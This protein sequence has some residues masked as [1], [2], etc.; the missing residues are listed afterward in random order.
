M[1][2]A[3]AIRHLDNEAL[4]I[5]FMNLSR[6]FSCEVFDLPEGKG[7]C[8]DCEGCRT[9]IRKFLNEKVNDEAFSKAIVLD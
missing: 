3:D 4:T 2:N 6:S 7:C 1:T 5:L 9:V 8:E